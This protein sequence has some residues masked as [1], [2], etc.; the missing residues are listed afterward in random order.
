MEQLS[1]LGEGSAELGELKGLGDKELTIRLKEI[2]GDAIKKKLQD[3]NKL[4]SSPTATKAQ[5][6]NI[7][8]QIAEWTKYDAKLKK[9]E[10][11]FKGT[12]NSV[13]GLGNGM[14]SLTTT[15]KGNGSAW[16]K[17][18][19]IIDSGIEI[20]DGIMSIIQIVKALTAATTTEQSAES[21]T[22]Q[23]TNS[24]EAATWTGLAAAKTAAAYASIPFLGEGLAAAQVAAIKSMVTAAAIP[25]FANGNIAYG[26]TLGIFGE[27]ANAS[28]NPEITAPLDKLR[29][30]IE[31]RGLSGEVEFRIKGRNLVGVAKKREKLVGRG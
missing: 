4:M 6:D 19:G 5:K 21:A 11:T 22:Q 10:V 20:F 9:S 7:R 28:R 16:D 29:S 24:A 12:W 18:T 2:G 14:K 27:Y 23:A 1:K 13:K 3:L 8:G 30:M 25:T 17:T 15:V 26:A 31:P